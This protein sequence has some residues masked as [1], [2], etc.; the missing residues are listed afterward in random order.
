MIPA[1]S[2]KGSAV[3]II[4]ALSLSVI[5]IAGSSQL[6]LSH[7]VGEPSFVTLV[8][9]SVILG[10]VIFFSDRVSSFSFTDLSV[11]LAAVLPAE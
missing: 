5:G 10:V 2:T 11:S 1:A 6:L 8:L 4:A 7:A 9:S 3:R